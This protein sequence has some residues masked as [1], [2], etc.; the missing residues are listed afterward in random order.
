MSMAGGRGCV[1]PFLV[2]PMFCIP[3]F[4]Y[5]VTKLPNK[6]CVVCK[7]DIVSSSLLNH[8]I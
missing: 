3:N 7:Y 5:F 2:E 8:I 4:C 1:F 6:E